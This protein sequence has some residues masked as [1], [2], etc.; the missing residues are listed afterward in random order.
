MC[1]D[2]DGGYQESGL[3]PA[4]RLQHA[5]SALRAHASQAKR[6]TVARENARHARVPGLLCR[7]RMLSSSR[8]LPEA[9]TLV[10]EPSNPQF[11]GS[12]SKIDPERMFGVCERSLPPDGLLNTKLEE[13]RRCCS[14]LE[15]PVR[16]HHKWQPRAHASRTQSRFLP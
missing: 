11:V 12:M 16:V 14:R 13:L 2:P 7:S 6:E 5:G 9:L 10:C 1:R 8:N 15:L 4:Q 3:P